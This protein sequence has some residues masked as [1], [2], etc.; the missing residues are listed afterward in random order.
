MRGVYFLA[1][2]AV[3]EQCVAFLRS[4]RTHNPTIPLCL[5]PFDNDFGKISLLKDLYSFSVLE[6]ARVLTTCDAISKK[7]HGF[8]LGTYRKLA[9]WEGVFDEFIYIDVDTVVI[10]SVDF[11]FAQLKYGHYVASHAN[12]TSTRRWV[13]KDNIYERNLL[14]PPQ[15]AYSANTGFFVSRRGL[16]T[17]QYCMAKTT[18]ALELK[19]S[20]ELDC[21]EQPFLNYLVV[22]SGYIY[23]SLLQLLATGVAPDVK[24]EWWAGRPAG[25]VE[26]GTLYDP[27][28]APIFLVHW[29]GCWKSLPYKKLWEFYRCRQIADDKPWSPIGPDNVTTDVYSV[30]AE[31][32]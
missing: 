18:G 29:A 14:T 26:R 27:N 32:T 20:M 30:E 5:I 31:Q 13:W 12:I 15:I 9:A 25:R 17:M 11:A 28:G 16:F 8:F 1:N 6:D 4:F 10:D 7:F 2:N 23:T 22:T 3:F 19:D 24:L 21:M